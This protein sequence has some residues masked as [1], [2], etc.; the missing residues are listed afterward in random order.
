MNNKNIKG[1]TLAE[2]LITLS[3]LG[4]VAAISIPAVINNIN[5]MI[6]KA[7]WK[8]AYSDFERVASLIAIDYKVNTFSDAVNLV[9]QET[10][11]NTAD[12]TATLFSK[13]FKA[14]KM[15][16]DSSSVKPFQCVNGT[17]WGAYFTVLG[18]YDTSSYKYGY[19]YLNG[20]DAGYFTLGYFV[21]ASAFQLEKYLFAWRSNSADGIIVIKTTP[22]GKGGVI[23]KDIFL[24]NMS[25]LND[26]KPAGI[27]NWY[28][29]ENYACNN[30]KQGQACSAK[31]LYEK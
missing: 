26:V 14:S 3:I 2:V 10:G 21:S 1:F 7:K 4:V 15:C 19:R 30:T 8:Q 28:T 24:L 9:K 17:P 22:T 27:K 23:G 29:D 25:N 20:Q 6:Y 31:Y 18:S 5:Q 13:Y 16:V 12:A 11:R